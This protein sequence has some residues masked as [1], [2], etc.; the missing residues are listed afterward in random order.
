[1]TS[2]SEA[3]WVDRRL[4]IPGSH[5]QFY[6]QRFVAFASEYRRAQAE[7]AGA[8]CESV[9][10]DLT[11]HIQQVGREAAMIRVDIYETIGR[12]TAG[13]LR[14]ASW[15]ALGEF[16]D[17][18]RDHLENHPYPLWRKHVKGHYLTGLRKAGLIDW[19]RWVGCRRLAHSGHQA[20]STLM[21]ASEGK[22]DVRPD[23]GAHV[24]GRH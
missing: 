22:A 24:V 20:M 2:R 18:V 12:P 9:K 15:Q 1:M 5:Y 21:F 23:L 10:C 17:R 3:S 4:G 16:D 19:P 7:Q 6:Q 8:N 11:T 13:S 14:P